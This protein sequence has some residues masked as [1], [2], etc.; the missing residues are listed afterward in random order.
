MTDS[1]SIPCLGGGGCLQQG[2]RGFAQRN[3]AIQ[4]LV[5]DIVGEHIGQ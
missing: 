4:I 1:A 2:S 3:L 5:F